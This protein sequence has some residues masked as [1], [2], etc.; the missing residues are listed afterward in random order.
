MQRHHCSDLQLFVERPTMPQSELD[1]EF[2]NLLELLDAHGSARA[3]TSGG[4]SASK[5]VANATTAADRLTLQN[6][7]LVVRIM[8]P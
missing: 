4:G 7:R 3:D 2:T 6:P 1:K 5:A 8:L